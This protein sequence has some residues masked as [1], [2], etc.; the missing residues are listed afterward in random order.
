MPRKYR[1]CVMPR[2]YRL[3]PNEA[4]KEDAHTQRL[5]RTTRGASSAVA[6]AWC[7][8]WT[9][10]TPPVLER[11]AKSAFL[12]SQDGDDRFRLFRLF[13]FLVVV[14]IVHLQKRLDQPNTM[15]V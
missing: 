3:R 4:G 1:P 8:L 6:H 7:V 10:T 11:S 9:L 12:P 15:S 14:F 2:K 13:L 5:S